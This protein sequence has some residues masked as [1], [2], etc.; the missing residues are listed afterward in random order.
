MAE[1]EPQ[2]P[3]TKTP[4]HP[5][6]TVTNITRKVRVLD[7]T[8]VSYAS[9]VSLFTLHARGYKVLDDINGTPP[10]AKTDPT[11][12]AWLEIDAHV[13]QWIY[14]TLSDEYLPRVLD[15]ENDSTAQ[16]AWDRVKGIFLNNKGARVAT[17]ETEFINL[18]LANM[19]SFDAYC[20]RLRELTSQLKDV[21]APVSDQRLVLQFVRGLP[22]EYDT[23][24]AYI[25]QTLSTFETA[26]SMVELEHHRTA[27]RTEP[28]T[29]LVAPADHT[30]APV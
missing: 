9:W 15:T 13:L 25:N 28:Q 14:G 3:P 7:G 6:Y 21:G 29:A 24:A 23:V 20:Q 26:R 27:R 11:Y 19:P 12:A 2:P 5:M 22:K 4:I 16:Q 10:P 8:K 1:E 18:T 17:L 30:A